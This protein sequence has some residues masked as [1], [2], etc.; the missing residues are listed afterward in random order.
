MLGIAVNRQSPLFD[1]L[2][3]PKYVNRTTLILRFLIFYFKITLFN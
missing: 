3:Q 1:G 2:I